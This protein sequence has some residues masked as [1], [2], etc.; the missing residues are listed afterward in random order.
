M[1]ARHVVDVPGIVG[2]VARDPGMEHDLQKQVAE[3]L[4][5]VL[6]A[7]ESSASS[8]SYVSSSR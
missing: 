8:V 6:R 1:P 7:A 5:E 2:G 3:L 4:L